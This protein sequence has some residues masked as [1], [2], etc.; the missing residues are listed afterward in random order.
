MRALRGTVDP[1]KFEAMR[2]T[3]SHPFQPGENQRIG[4][5]VIDFQGE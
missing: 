5:E 2:G 4:V 3:V 1:E